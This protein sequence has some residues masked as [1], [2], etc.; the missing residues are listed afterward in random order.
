MDKRLNR[1]FIFLILLISFIWLVVPF[2]MAILWSLVD[3]SEPW[4]VDRIFPPVVSFYR[5]NYMWENS[6]LKEAL[7]NSYVLAPT[8]ALCCLVLSI[9]TSFAFG[10]LQFKGKETAKLLTLLPI[11]L[12]PFVTSI[13]FSSILFEIG[14]QYWKFGNVLIAHVVLFIPFAIRIMTVCFEQVKQDVIDAARDL[15]ASKFQ[16]FKVAY[17]PSLKSGIFASILIVFIL[18]IEEFA[19]AFIIGAPDFITIPTILYSALGQDFVRPNAAVISLILVFPN[20]IL[21]IF[22]ERVLRSANP[23]LFSGK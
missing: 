5:W 3:P 20:V 10:R 4:T 2:T 9:P 7:L 21:M 11:V 17:L 14:F 22:L 19:I 1:L 15:S 18:S 23:T 12:P 16:V 13:Y 8:T 6:N